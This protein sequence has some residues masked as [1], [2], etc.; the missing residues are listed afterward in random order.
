[1]THAWPICLSRGHSRRVRR[2]RGVTAFEV[3]IVMALLGTLS[4]MAVPSYFKVLKRTAG[5]G[6]IGDLSA[7]QFAIDT[8]ERMNERLPDS[9]DDLGPG[10]PR[11]DRWGNPYVYTPSTSEDWMN[12]RRLDQHQVPLNE[13]Y[14]LFSAGP[15]GLWKKPLMNPQSHDDIVRADNG[16]FIGIALD[17]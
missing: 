6:A 16:L 7:L 14:D 2:R 8:Y 13:D 11:I 15:D 3:L 9:L 10:P 1:M 5:K 12:D 17:H 4:A